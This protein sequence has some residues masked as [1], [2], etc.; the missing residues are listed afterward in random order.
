MTLEVRVS[1]AA[2]PPPAADVESWRARGPPVLRDADG[3]LRIAESQGAFRSELSLTVRGV[4]VTARGRG[5]DAGAA[6]RVACEEMAECGRTHGAWLA[7]APEARTDRG[8]RV[9]SRERALVELELANAG[10]LVYV[11]A[12]SG[13]LTALG[14]GEDGGIDRVPLDAP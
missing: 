9:L 1:G 6:A 8:R 2:S 7:A 3:E 5:A 10:V 13:A 11:D 4:R 12:E 14:R